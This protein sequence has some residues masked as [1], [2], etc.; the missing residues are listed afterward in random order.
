MTWLLLGLLLFLG[1]HSVGLF[2]PHWRERV[3][4]RIGRQPWR[5]L[6][7]LVAL[8]G[9]VLV[10]HG[11]GEARQAPVLLYVPPAWLAHVSSLLV[12]AAFVL[13]AAAYVPGNRIRTAAGHP[14]LAGV[15]LWAG[16]HLLATGALHEVLLFGAFL[17]WAVADF[18]QLRRR[19]RAT[20]VTPPR[21]RLSGDV[22]TVAAGG[23]AWVAF[24]LWLH[25]WLIGIAPL[26]RV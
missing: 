9:I 2:A 25:A 20:G 22:V 7:S 26:A 4:A 21:G 12:L 1:C 24:A 10:V 3:I 5:G 8:A 11:F 16:A 23:V 17:A 18:I 15:K 13:V 19:D 6:Y 14:M